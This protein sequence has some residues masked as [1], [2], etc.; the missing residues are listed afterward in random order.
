MTSYFYGGKEVDIIDDGFS[1]IS[2]SELEDYSEVHLGALDVAVLVT[3]GI[4]Q[5]V[6]IPEVEAHETR[7]N[8]I[9]GAP[10][11]YGRI[12][13][14]WYA[15]ERPIGIEDADVEYFYKGNLLTAKRFGLNTY[16]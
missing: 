4:S 12:A 13:N 3:D 7:E 1:T 16:L 2:R 11:L 9:G 15:I 10:I 5:I 14:S 6:T 8:Q